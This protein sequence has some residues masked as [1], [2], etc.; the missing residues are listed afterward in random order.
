MNVRRRQ[1]L[2][3]ALSLVCVLSVAAALITYSLRQNINLFYT[4]EQVIHGRSD[5]R[6]VEANQV[7][8]L[9]GVVVK[10]SVKRDSKSLSVHF[11]L[12]N[13]GRDNV[14]VEYTGILPDLFREGQGIVAEGRLDETKTL[15]ATQVLAKHDEN[16]QPPGVSVLPLSDDKSEVSLVP[17]LKRNSEVKP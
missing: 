12:T 17:S 13:N 2:M 3:V 1:R 14:A 4:P 8:R 11:L 16:Y 5:G 9:G 10:G 6:Q 15:L 7:I